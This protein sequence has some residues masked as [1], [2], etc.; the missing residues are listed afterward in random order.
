[1]SGA[2][3]KREENRGDKG[4]ESKKKEIK[5]RRETKTFEE[6]GSAREKRSFLLLF[7]PI[8]LALGLPTPPF[9]FNKDFFFFYSFISPSFA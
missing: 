5:K 1:M 7:G 4:R 3:E 8:F 6:V 2:S 9:F